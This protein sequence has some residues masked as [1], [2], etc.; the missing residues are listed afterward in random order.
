MVDT[1]AGTDCTEQMEQLFRVPQNEIIA[2]DPGVSEHSANV[3]LQHTV[4]S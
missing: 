1:Q 3:H 2:R 4:G